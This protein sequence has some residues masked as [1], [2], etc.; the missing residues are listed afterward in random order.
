MLGKINSD[1]DSGDPHR[2][3]LQPFVF[4]STGYRMPVGQIA[5]V[6]TWDFMHDSAQCLNPETFDGHRIVKDP[7]SG[8]QSSSVRGTVFTD[9]SKDFPIWGLG[10]EV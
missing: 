7:Q 2:K 10:F 3:A 1:F 6:P 4:Q 8:N 9:A 5:C